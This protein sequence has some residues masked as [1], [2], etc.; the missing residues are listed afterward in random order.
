MKIKGKILIIMG[1][2]GSFGNAVLN[3][4]LHTNHFKEIHFFSRN[5]KKQDDIRTLLK[6]EKLKFNYTL[7]VSQLKYVKNI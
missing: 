2:K 5:K 3:S 4:F 1:D 6:S 7:A